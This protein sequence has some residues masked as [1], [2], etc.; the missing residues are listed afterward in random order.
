MD[1]PGVSLNLQRK[2]ETTDFDVSSVERLRGFYGLGMSYGFHGM[3]RFSECH[4]V[5]T[6]AYSP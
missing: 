3:N 1:A 2:I 6:Q 4:F 5:R